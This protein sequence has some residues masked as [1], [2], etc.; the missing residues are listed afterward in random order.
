MIVHHHVSCYVCMYVCIR[1][2]AAAAASSDRECSRPQ[3][4]RLLRLHFAA[5]SAVC[6]YVCMYVYMKGCY[7]CAS[8]FQ[9][10]CMCEFSTGW[11]TNPLCG[12]ACGTTNQVNLTQIG[13]SKYCNNHLVNCI[14]VCSMYVCMHKHLNVL[15]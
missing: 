10:V 12:S 6:M 5:H 11:Y 14:Y 13:N 2:G 8:I 3:L 4:A 9:N 1:P 7:K 15:N